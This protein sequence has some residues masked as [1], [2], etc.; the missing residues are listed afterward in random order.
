MNYSCGH[1]VSPERLQ[2]LSERE[3]LAWVRW[4][5]TDGVCAACWSRVMGAKNAGEEL[6]KI[7]RGRVTAG[8]E[9][10]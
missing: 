8:P 10:K 6:D 9:G 1:E 3:A 4:A 7:K 2:S 5:A